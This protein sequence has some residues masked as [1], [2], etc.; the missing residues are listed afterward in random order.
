L[1]ESEGDWAG[2]AASS[3]KFIKTGMLG[4]TIVLQYNKN[5]QMLWRWNVVV[6]KK[7]YE[8]TTVASSFWWCCCLLLV[9]NS[10]GRRKKRNQKSEIAAILIGG[11]PFKTFREPRT[12]LLHVETRETCKR[13]DSTFPFKMAPIFLNY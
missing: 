9:L 12:R 1:T 10:H 8:G 11:G 13:Q 2:R 7:K 4:A 3:C 6:N 5:N